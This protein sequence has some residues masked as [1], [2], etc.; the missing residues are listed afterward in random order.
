MP[1]SE[2]IDLIGIQDITKDVTLGE[3]AK[4]ISQNNNSQVQS[5]YS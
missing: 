1:L 5:D 4:E 2:V 3:L